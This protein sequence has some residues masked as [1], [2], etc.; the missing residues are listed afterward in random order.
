MFLNSLIYPQSFKK[1]QRDLVFTH[2]E[3]A[4]LKKLEELNRQ[5][6]RQKNRR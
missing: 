2:E 4:Y 1:L 5:K 3:M 6:R